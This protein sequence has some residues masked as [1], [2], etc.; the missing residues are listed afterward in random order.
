MQSVGTPVLVNTVEENKK[1]GQLRKIEE[2]ICS[3]N[4]DDERNF[5][6]NDKVTMRKGFLHGSN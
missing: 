5:P 1:H 2:P 6:N 4:H 3:N